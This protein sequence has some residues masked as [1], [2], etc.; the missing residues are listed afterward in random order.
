MSSNQSPP[1]RSFIT[2]TGIWNDRPPFVCVLKIPGREKHCC[3]SRQSS[4]TIL[5]TD[6]EESSLYYFAILALDIA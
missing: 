4:W 2:G 1:G 3:F 6:F 5:K